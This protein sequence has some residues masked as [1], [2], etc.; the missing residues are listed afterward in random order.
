V[1]SPTT[2]YATIGA[3]GTGIAALGGSLT[4]CA[5]MPGLAAYAAYFAVSGAIL[6]AV[7]GA[8]SLVAKRLQGV[9]TPD[10]TDG[11]S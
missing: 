7:G 11:A 3:V 9:A 10:K 1:T 8:V 2:T 6:F 5:A 4:A